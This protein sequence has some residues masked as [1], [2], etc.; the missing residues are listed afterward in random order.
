M[1]I[2]VTRGAEVDSTFSE[3]RKRW[4]RS[5]SKTAVARE[6]GGEGSEGCMGVVSLRNRMA[7]ELTQSSSS[8][9]DSD[10][11]SSRAAGQ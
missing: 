9:E 5:R 8:S 10:S 3:A 6:R 7:F 4:W 11:G 1:S 2:V